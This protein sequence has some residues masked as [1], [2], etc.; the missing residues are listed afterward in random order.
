MPHPRTED[1][2]AYIFQRILLSGTKSHLNKLTSCTMVLF[3]CLRVQMF[4]PRVT[5]SFIVIHVG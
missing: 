5:N 3:A 1:E 4:L 2:K